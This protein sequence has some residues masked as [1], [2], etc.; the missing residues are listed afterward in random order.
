VDDRLSEA[1]LRRVDDVCARFEDAW[2][3]GQRPSPQEFLAAAD[4]PE[5]AELL[6]ELLRLDIHYRRG[7]GERVS[8]DD[9]EGHFPQDGPLIRAV[10]AE[11]TDRDSLRPS[12]LIETSC[13]P[14]ASTRPPAPWDPTHS[15]AA[16]EPGLP[17]VPG[18]ENL[19]LLGR[20]GMGVVY[21]ARQTSLKRVVALKMI[22][23]GDFAGPQE[24]ARF[25]AEAEA[26]AR[27]RHPNIVQIHEVGEEKGC[28]FFSL[29]F[30]E[31]GSLDRRVRGTPQPP[32]LAA[33]L[34]AV[35]ARAMHVA[36]QSGV[37]HRDLKP[38][39]VL[40]GRRP[41]ALPG[42][43]EV[44]E[45]PLE[46]FEPKI[47]DFGLA[48]RLGEDS[49]QTRSGA[50][51]GTPSYM[52]PEQAAGRVREVGPAADIYA[53]TAI[54]YELL[55]GRPPFK[56]ASAQET[57]EQVCTQ[58][59]VPVRQLQPKVSRDL[60]TICL[61]GLRKDIHQRYASAQDLADDLQ[62]WL[63]GR[64]ILARPVPAWE[65]GWK[66]VQRR[67]ALAGL[68]ALAAVA[69][70]AGS[71]SAVLFGLVEHQKA[72][73]HEREA[74]GVRTVQEKYVQGQRAEDDQQFDKA[75]EHYD[76]ALA[77]LNAEPGAAGE[78]MRRSL[79]DAIA[80]VGE[81]QKVLGRLA[82]RHVFAGRRERFR[83]H[84][85]EVRFRAVHFRDQDAGDDA[86][87][88]RREAPLALAE[89][90]LD[91]GDPQRLARG[92]GPFRQLVEAPGQLDRLAEEC[93]EV[94]LAWADAEAVAPPPDGPNRALRLLDGAD[95]LGGAHELA[96]SRA[97]H[98]RRATCLDLL[99]DAPGARRERERAAGIAPTTALDHFEAALTAYRS[100]RTQEAFDECAQA[101][102]AHPDDFWA[103]YLK[104]LC[105]LR[106]Q[107]WGE[108]EE[109]LNVC[110]RQRPDFAWLFPL[111]GAAHGGLRQFPAAEADFARAL[112]PST[113]PA[114]R[115]FAL[116]NRSVLR[117][118]QR[119]QADAESD[120]REAIGLQP[121]VYQGYVTLADVLKAEGDRPG[122]LKLLDQALDLCPDNPALYS[123]RARL[124]ALSGHPEAAR[125]DFE[126]VI[127]REPPG[128]RSDRLVAARVELAHLKHLAGEN[129]AAL[130]DCDAVIAAR[131]DFPEAHRQR[132]EVLLAL[133]GR[134]KDA[135]AELDEY[136]RL[137]GKPTPEAHRARGLLHAQRREYAKAVEAYTQALL[138]RR[139]AD[140]LSNR[141]W[142]YLMQDALRPALDD[143][144][145]ALKLN[146]KDADALA[147][148][149]TALMIRGRV[150][151]VAEATAAAEK[152]LRPR[153][154]TVPRLMAC[155]GIY[156]RAAIVLEAADDPDAGRCL[157]R[158][159][160]LLREAMAQVPEK[161]RPTF[162]RDG[163]LTDPALR[164]LQRT[165]EMLEL[166]R[167]Y[168]P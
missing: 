76:Q 127:A 89:L 111:L 95:A 130:T 50:I 73:A 120:L 138:L 110:L 153:P 135:G 23:S 35:L 140:V 7:G 14:F 131:P 146:P 116:T 68:A 46:A 15:P 6:R 79:E 17:T 9:Y 147:G 29:E 52:A 121:K 166:G 96:T 164:P 161:E 80:R 75:K 124:H 114:L 37:V 72:K 81:R 48:K 103:Q 31:G 16:A 155:T 3:K 105:H 107:R 90:G 91:A 144:D 84:Y 108:A 117:R 5:R 109:V 85:D 34:V 42:A 60:E 125:R 113:D 70:L 54:L 40:L 20:G 149:G 150:A 11:R 19:G 158:A 159:L 129:A 94:L 86:A 104:A 101:L 65:R 8:A 115:A 74:W 55:T 57:M 63:D 51:L 87:A 43:A 4:G 143:F 12:P 97:M 33:G 69:L 58:E 98:L 151:D 100:G 152:S 1:A 41:D 49:G 78:D 77:T 27:L 102:R 56:G 25:R 123:E 18:Y 154:W 167:A 133:G 47:S 145:A 126:Q 64:P 148:R 99:G 134:S 162:W 128:G 24:L 165:P 45:P 30:M 92:L 28:P 21:K 119:R 132:A 157:R 71:S 141:G 61:K 38:A 44:G 2:R 67:P 106:D 39:N 66:W 118:L 168:A 88:V 59:P 36:H 32:R 122:A 112:G 160:A 142:A 62:R 22:L 139:D 93:V 136:L 83:A 13:D 156:A 137:G 163:V 53:L 26:I 10:F 82:E